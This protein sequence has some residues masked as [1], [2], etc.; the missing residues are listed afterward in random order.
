MK[1]TPFQLYLRTMVTGPGRF[2][3]M[4]KEEA[5]ERLKRLTRQDYG[6]DINRWREWGEKHPETEGIW[7]Q[8]TPEDGKTR[9]RSRRGVERAGSVSD[10]PPVADASGSFRRFL[11]P[12]LGKT[13]GRKRDIRDCHG[14][15]KGST[16]GDCPH[17][18]GGRRPPV[19]G[20]IH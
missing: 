14:P 13:S 10:G 7:P 4:S 15:I 1:L 2:S 11:V 12:A 6:F 5:Y 19:P 17:Y 9:C 20:A 3:R 8:E 16:G 18:G